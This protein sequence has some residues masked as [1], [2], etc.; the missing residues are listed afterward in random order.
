MNLLKQILC[1]S[2]STTLLMAS[3]VNQVMADENIKVILDGNELSF[4]VSPQIIN[5]RTMVPLRSIFEALGASVDWDQDTQTVTSTKNDITVKLTIDSSTM[6]V[7]EN[8]VTLDSP[9]C[10]VEERTLVPVRA[11]SEAYNTTVDWEGD[12]RTVTIS[13]DGTVITPVISYENILPNIQQINDFINNGM[14]IEA[15]QECEN[16]KAWHVI[17]PEDTNIIDSLYNVAKSKYESY[18]E[19]IRQES[20]K[21]YDS[22]EVKAQLI[23][24]IHECIRIGYS[25]YEPFGDILKYPYTA[26]FSTDHDPTI[27]CS[28]NGNENYQFSASVVGKVRAQS[29]AGIMGEMQYWAAIYY[30][31]IGTEV[32]SES[33]QFIN[34]HE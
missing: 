18:M 28:T 10:I 15:M 16:A 1:M 8:A 30:N 19:T 23:D 34:F 31:V 17:S 21:T 29:P 7:N 26:D 25:G 13:T 4:D 5:D 3:A 11:I 14:Y 2:L 22:D 27:L 6:Y 12:T 9:A 20:L 33:L 32:S 24:Y